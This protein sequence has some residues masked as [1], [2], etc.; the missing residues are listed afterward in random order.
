MSHFNDFN[1]AQVTKLPNHL[2]Q[3]IVAQNYEKYTPIDQAVWRYVMRQNYSYLKNVAYYPYIKGLQRAGLSI[4]HIPDLQTMNDNLGKIGWGAVTVDGF[5]PPAAFMEYQAYRVLVIAADIRQINHIEYTPAPD[6][7]HESAGHAPII[8][9]TDYNNYLSYFGSIGAKAMFSAKD[10]ELYEAIR[11]LSIL[12]EAIDA[13]EFQIAKAEKELR[14]IS[15][16]MGEPSEMA[17]LGRLHWWTVEYGLIGTLENPKIYGAGLL[18]SIGESA[19]CM[20][21]DVEKLWYNIDTINYA[22]DITKPQPQL[23]VTET[24]QNLIDVLET[25]ANTMAFRKGGTES[26]MK[27][28][29]CKNVATAV[30]SS[31]LQVS[32]VFTDIGVGTKDEVT[33]IKTTGPSALAFK[34]KQLNGHGKDY[35]ADGFSSPVGRLKDAAKALED[36]S[37][38]ELQALG[39]IT[40]EKTELLFESGIKVIGV[41]KDI[42]TESNKLLLIA[43]KDCTVTESN[44]NILFKPEWGIYDMAIGETIVSVFNGAA[45]KDAY[46]EITLISNEK[47]HQLTYDDKILKLHGLYQM[48]REIRESGEGLDKLAE[49]FAQLKSNHRQDWLCA[50][51]ILEI[52]YHKKIYHQLEKEI[53]VYLEIKAGRELDH[54]K[55]I[56]DGLHVIKNPVSQLITED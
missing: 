34:G 46:E 6:I 54:T 20:Q 26:I 17:L 29:A 51:E 4:E 53:Q 19:T 50:L 44:G 23:F 48:V 13:D 45:D 9:D 11:K 55:L 2:K 16:N 12:K 22:Y 5:I 15:E 56:S 27:A 7:I 49:I 32:G 8:A 33:F 36:Y 47:T 37:T 52:I 1:N 21:N 38:A 28:I 40:G 31:G 41:I 39:I 3:F 43:L 35:H 14:Y 10:F 42:I 18:S 24:F 30:C 25:F